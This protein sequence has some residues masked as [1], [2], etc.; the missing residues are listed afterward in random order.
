VETVGSLLDL[1]VE[2]DLE[3]LEEDLD[4]LEEDL[5]NLGVDLDNLEVD[6]ENLEVDL[7]NLVDSAGDVVKEAGPQGLFRAEIRP[8]GSLLHFQDFLRL[9]CC[10]NWNQE[11]FLFSP[12]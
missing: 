8:L 3:N 6:L 2:E 11:L 5:D 12:R 4:N 10:S 9:A 1:Q 7:R